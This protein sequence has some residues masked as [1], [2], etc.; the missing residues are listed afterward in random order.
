MPVLKRLIW[1][2]LPLFILIS[3]SCTKE[4]S[5]QSTVMRRGRLYKIGGEAPFTGLVIGKGRESRHTQL[6]AYKKSYKDGLL[7]GETYFYYPNGKIESLVPYSN[8]KINGALICYWPN[9]KPK[10]RIHFINGL[11]GGAAG[12]MFWD[13]NGHQL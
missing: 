10:S 9:G 7:D 8:G 6:M 2:L 3:T 11:R 12:E 5:V 1:G 4:I 13:K